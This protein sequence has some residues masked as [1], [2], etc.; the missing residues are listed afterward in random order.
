[1]EILNNL[2]TQ[3]LEILDFDDSDKT[4]LGCNRSYK[5]NGYHSLVY[6]YCETE[7]LTGFNYTGSFDF[8]PR[9]AFSKGFPTFTTHYD[10]PPTL[11]NTIR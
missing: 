10:N 5:V 8:E 4:Y 3:T 6:F 1:M 9:D 7:L 11:P 2:T